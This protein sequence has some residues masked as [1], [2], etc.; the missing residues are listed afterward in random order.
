MKTIKIGD[1]VQSHLESHVKG[2]AVEFISQHAGDWMVGSTSSPVIYCVIELDDGNR[3][4][5]KLSDLHYD[6]DI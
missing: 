2:T 1:R 6:Y 4:K 5:Y 3:I